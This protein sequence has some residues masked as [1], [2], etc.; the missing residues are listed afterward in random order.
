MFKCLFALLLVSFVQC[1]PHLIVEKGIDTP[2]NYIGCNHDFTI[3]YRV[4]NIGEEDVYNVTINDQWPQEG[5]DLDVE[6]PIVISELPAGEKAGY[7][8]TVR[9]MYEYT[10]YKDDVEVAQA[11][12]MST[13]VGTLPILQEAHY[14]RLAS[15]FVMEYLIIGAACVVVIG[16]PFLRWISIS[17]KVKTA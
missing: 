4:D 5:F 9:A 10:Y 6:Y 12:G 14:N 3:Y 1:A 15:S 2:S 13:S 16:L 11:R 7:L 8:E 17:A